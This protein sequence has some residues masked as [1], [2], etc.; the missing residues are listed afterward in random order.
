MTAREVAEAMDPTLRYTAA[1]LLDGQISLPASDRPAVLAHAITI[2]SFVQ[3]DPRGA[4]DSI[5][6]LLSTFRDALDVDAAPVSSPI[7]AEAS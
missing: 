6:E 2:I 4:L 3:D 7:G 1:A 5:I